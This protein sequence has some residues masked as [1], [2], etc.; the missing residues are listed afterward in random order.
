[1]HNKKTKLFL[2]LIW[3]FLVAFLSL[4]TLAD[5]GS[6]VNIPNKDKIVHFTFYFVFVLLWLSFFN[7]VNPSSKNKWLVLIAAI[8]FGVLME[9]GQ[10]VFTTTR[11][12][13]GF[14]VLANSVGAILGTIFA[15]QSY[16]KNNK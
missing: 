14:D 10:G 8:L 11:T 13:D 2:A 3:T 7:F 1:V 9:I 16:K 5:V 15:S 4:A 6:E 12:P